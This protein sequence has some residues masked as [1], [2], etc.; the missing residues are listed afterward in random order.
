VVEVELPPEVQQEEESVHKA[1]NPVAQVGMEDLE[2]GVLV[3]MEEVL[4]I[5]TVA[6]ALR[7]DRPQQ[8]GHL[9][10]Q[11]SRSIEKLKMKHANGHRQ[12]LTTNQTLPVL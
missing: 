9:S 7:A 4:Q 8:G 11:L 10:R 5:L 6:A 2:V 12:A 1:N 3:D